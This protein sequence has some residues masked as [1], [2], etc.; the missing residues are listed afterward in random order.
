MRPI[1]IHIGTMPNAESGLIIIVPEAE[2]LVRPFRDRYDARAALGVPAH[3]TVLYPF[4]PPDQIDD[5]ML[6]K[7][8]RCS[9]GFSPIEFSLPVISAL[10]G[11]SPI[12]GTRTRGTVSPI[13]DRGVGSLSGNAAVWR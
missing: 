13:D 10:C 7:L 1:L 12:P 9:S 5:G 6:D 3:I 4:K 11:C 8:H 2:A